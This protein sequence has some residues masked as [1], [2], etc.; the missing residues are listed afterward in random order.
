MTIFCH[1][2]STRNPEIGINP[3]Y[4][5][6]NIWRLGQVRNTK[7]GAI[8]SN[9]VLLNAAKYQGYIFYL[10]WDIKEKPRGWWAEW[11]GR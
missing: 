9:D 1:K 4:V 6:P 5:L 11:G 3:A 7:F 2:G 8:V 10:F